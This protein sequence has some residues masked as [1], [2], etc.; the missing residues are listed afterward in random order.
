MRAQVSELAK[1][2]GIRDRRKVR[3]APARRS[4]EVALPASTE[5]EQLSL[6]V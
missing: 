4:K 3:L 5:P 2:Y 1:E 6:T